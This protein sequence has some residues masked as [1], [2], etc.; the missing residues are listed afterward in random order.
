MRYISSLIGK[1]WRRASAS[2]AIAI[3]LPGA[4]AAAWGPAQNIIIP[5]YTSGASWTTANGACPLAVSG[6]TVFLVWTFSWFN[7]GHQVIYKYNDGTTWRGDSTIG[8]LGN[9]RLHNWYP[10]CALDVA[11][12]LH[13]VWESGE[14][15]YGAGYDL[16]YT[17]SSQGVWNGQQHF[18]ASPSNTWHPVIAA[19]ADG[20]VYVC[21]QDDRDGGFR[22]YY[23][24]LGSA[25][26]GGDI[27]VPGSQVFASSPSIAA[28]GSSIAVAWQ[29][30]RSGVFQ[31]HAKELGPAGWGED[32]AV[33][34]SSQGAYAPCLASDAAGNYHLVWE[35]WQDGNAEIYYRRYDRAG[36]TWGPETRITAE[37]WRSR[38]PVLVCRGDSL[39]DVF[40][41]DDRSG[42]YQIMSRTA[43]RGSWGTDTTLT[44][45]WVD[46]RCPAVCA[47]IRGNLHLVWSGF[48]VVPATARPA[49]FSMSDM[50][51]PWPK[52]GPAATATPL[53][54]GPFPV[55][56]FPNPA[57]GPALIAFRDD[58]GTGAD[59]AVAIYAV[60]GQL[61][62]TINPGAATGESR[63]V[64]WDGRDDRGR[65]VAGGVYLIA[66]HQGRRT[67]TARLV[68]VR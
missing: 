31:I 5:V 65:A 55:S 57:A 56:V 44:T 14:Y 43:F 62:R 15:E 40:W 3:L 42:Y 34:R 47:D 9:W 2:V 60:T 16:S 1:I 24:V 10:S 18:V 26:W 23:K 49:L 67:A 51:N 33:S 36:G 53:P 19:A 8:F 50:V 68:M 37:P 45:G 21:W 11:G 58:R 29:D 48:G 27:A 20:K 22:L 39:V 52:A 38:A 6:D 7:A 46:S 61:V 4:A 41:E 12:R 66:V 64:A 30:F 25:G 17:S 54:A 63:L 13:V 28:G 32:S 35:D 59:C